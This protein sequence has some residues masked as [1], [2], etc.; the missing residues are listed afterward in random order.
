MAVSSCPSHCYFETEEQLI[1]R[2]ERPSSCWYRLSRHGGAAPEDGG[3]DSSRYSGFEYSSF[4]FLLLSSARSCRFF[5]A[6]RT[7]RLLIL[8]S[9]SSWKLLVVSVI[10]FGFSIE[11]T[12]SFLTR[13]LT[14][15]PEIEG[16]IGSAFVSAC[17]LQIWC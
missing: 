14:N 12:G 9:R 6:G 17:L 10:S 4:S 5:P 1:V 2:A 7:L 3:T 16:T 8:R 13:I 11:L 15:K